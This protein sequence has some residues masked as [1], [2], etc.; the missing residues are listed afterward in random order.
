M[1]CGGGGGGDGGGS[2]AQTLTIANTSDDGTIDNFGL[3]PDGETGVNYPGCSA[4][5]SQPA[6][7]YYRFQLT[8]PIPAGA[9]PPT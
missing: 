8:E 1:R 2:S 9:I 4:S 5:T 6:W 7:S 3:F